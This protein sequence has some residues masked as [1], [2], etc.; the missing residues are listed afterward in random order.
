MT[1]KPKYSIGFMTAQTQT[2]E[3]GKAEFTTIYISKETRKAL[4]RIKIENDLRTYEDVIRYLLR[5][6]YG[7]Q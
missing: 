5:K 7:D 6:V 3:R 4:A 1:F 2:E